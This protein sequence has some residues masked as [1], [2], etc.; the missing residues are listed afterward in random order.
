MATTQAPIVPARPIKAQDTPKIPPRPS[1][2]GIERAN[3]PSRDRFAP[4]PLDSILSKSPNKS[5]FTNGPSL[6]STP[7]GGDIDR[8]GSVD[9]PS[10]GQEGSEYA[11]VAESFSQAGS[12]SSRSASPEHTRTVADDLKLHAPKPSLPAV[13]AKERVAAVTRT[14]S[15]RAASFG[16]GQASQVT[17]QAASQATSQEA[18][19]SDDG[20]EVDEHG[21]PAIGRQVP[22]YPNA[23]DVQ[24]PT[25]AEVAAAAA[26]EKNHHRKKSARG[27]GELPPDSYG[28]HG[29]GVIP[30]DKL[31]RAY[32]SK[33]PELVK[34]EHTP[35]HSDRAQDYSLPSADLNK[36]VRESASR[37]RVDPNDITPSEQVGWQAIDESTSRPASVAPK[38][39]SS[40]FSSQSST[41]P[42]ILKSTIKKNPEISFSAPPEDP[43]AEAD[44]GVI[45][46]EDP[47]S[48]RRKS[49]MF[50]EDES[51]DLDQFDQYDQYENETPILALD[52]LAKDPAAYDNEPAVRPSLERSGS[53]FDGQGSSSRPTSRPS[54]VFRDSH[55][56]EESATA[57]ADDKDEYEPLFKDDDSKASKPRSSEDGHAP[58]FPSRDI[59]EDAPSSAHY[60]AEVNTPDMQSKPEGDVEGTVVRRA[61]STVSERDDETPAQAFARHQEELAEKELHGADTF[62]ENRKPHKPTSWATH[63]ATDD[64]VATSGISTPASISAS[65]TA[66]TTTSASASSS[67]RPAMNRFPSRDVWEDAPESLQLQTEVS[68]PQEDEVSSPADAIKPDSPQVAQVPQVPQRPAVPSRPKPKSVDGA[69]AS[70]RPKPQIPSRPVRQHLPVAVEQ[71]EAEAESASPPKTKPAVPARPFGGKI[72]ALQ[73]TFMSDLNKK[74]KIGP[75]APKKDEPEPSAE[76]AEEVAEKEKAPLVDARKGRARGPQRRAPAARPV[77]TETESAPAASAGPVTLGFS[78]TTTLYSIDPEEGVV[79]VS[80]PAPKAVEPV[81]LEAKPVE[82]P[83]VEEAEDK[84][85][86]VEAG[87]EAVTE[88]EAKEE[89]PAAAAASTT[90]EETPAKSSTTEAETIEATA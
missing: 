29:H 86:N 33:H 13:S 3:S 82:V 85:P 27:F 59:W 15:D 74:L 81:A 45:H 67:R 24:A 48:T 64:D 40:S 61:S 35:H 57:D 66:P 28:L 56:P 90:E 32:Y 65:T 17:S 9:L 11:A 52:E 83:A 88:A 55:I 72:A 84:N 21:I 49:V 63:T 60:T 31:E 41:S 16:I 6:L 43:V 53:S 30:S 44:S 10:V 23:G 76:A 73:A 51:P 39:K 1:R 70:D 69:A 58:R 18:P 5:S 75:Q 54:S 87:A 25:P 62:A 80:S 89:T 34:L 14:D 38:G 26:S 46:V 37:T 19:A 4:S 2:R 47:T 68:N 71:P 8:S 78:T 22:M 50:S 36:I 20:V 77:A 79:S 12:I 42:T 7:P